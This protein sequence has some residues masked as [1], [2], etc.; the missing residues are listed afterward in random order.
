MLEYLTVL[1]FGS[2]KDPILWILAI[3][4]GTNLFG[5]K[6]KYLYLI[7]A[8]IIWGLIRYYVYKSLGEDISFDLLL[9]IVFICI[10]LM[11]II[12]FLINII[13][14][15]ILQSDKSDT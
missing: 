15:Y 2:I 6:N 12:G 3:G 9:L 5:I 10:C 7:L 8:G 13:F 4:I 1:I 14:T 11:F